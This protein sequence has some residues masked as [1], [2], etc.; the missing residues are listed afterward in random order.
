MHLRVCVCYGGV[1]VVGRYKEMNVFSIVKGV[2]KLKKKSVE[3][4]IKKLKEE[5]VR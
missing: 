4:M 1:M 2:P 3:N 5:I